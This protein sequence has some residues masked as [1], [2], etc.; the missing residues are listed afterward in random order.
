MPERIAASLLAVDFTHTALYDGYR[1]HHA[2]GGPAGVA[3]TSSH[4]AP[5]TASREDPPMTSDGPVAQIDPS[6][7]SDL[8]GS[9]ALMIDVREPE[10]WRIGHIAAAVHIPLGDLRP[11]SVPRDRVVVAVCRSGNR[12][13][14]AAIQLAAA[15]VDVRNL[16][17]GMQAWAAHGLPITTDGGAP[18]TVG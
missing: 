5:L 16:A 9:G 4:T 18:G 3:S 6:T 12:S 8:A 1:L 15:G 2:A 14:K 7:A 13:G 11:D 17:G 10:E